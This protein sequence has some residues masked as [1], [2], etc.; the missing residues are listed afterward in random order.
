MQR[1]NT[2]KIV[3]GRYRIARLLGQG[4]MGAVYRAWDLTLN[5]PVA[6]KEMLPDNTLN[7]NMIAEFRQQFKQEAQV[8]ANLHHPNLPRVTD[9]FEWNGN[10]YLIMDFV[11]GESLAERIERQ[12]PLPQ[13]QVLV[14]TEQLL[15]ALNACHQHGIL[16]RD[17]KPENIIIRRDD[18]AILVD[19]GLVKLWD[20]NKPKTQRII[21]GMGTPEYASPEH[22]HLNNRHT[23]PRSDIYSLAATLYHALTGYPPPSCMERATQGSALTTPQQLGRD[24]SPEVERAILQALSVNIDERFDDAHAMKQALNQRYASPSPT[25]PP[26]PSQDEERKPPKIIRGRSHTWLLEMGTGMLMAVLGTLSLNAVLFGDRIPTQQYLGL[27]VGSIVLGG[28]GWFAGDTVFQAL[29]MPKSVAT[30]SA[31]TGGGSGTAKMPGSP[32]QRLVMK[33]RK[34]IQHLTP[35][36]QI[37]MLVILV[38]VAGLAAWLLGPVIASVPFLWNY[39]PSYAFAAPLAYAAVGKRLGRAGAAHL[40]VTTIGGL[41]LS[42]S[43]GTSSTLG[44]L[45]IAG[46]VGA[47]L[48]EGLAL[49]AS[50]TYLR[51]Q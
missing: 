43:T 8:L 35:T 28:I 44:E 18:R 9:F 37:G 47:A 46:L 34:L 33:T 19:F 23:E 50:E 22:L 39:L 4:G 32:T 45:L 27:S 42:A 6:L 30:Y 11:E 48:I 51:S 49:L 20:P 41:A 1:L 12:G 26:L 7:P 40:L 29:T 15:D 3:N 17:I 38:V 16:H 36:Q 25:P 5:I 21:R 14:W 13:H 2:G 10:D 31:Q 24:V